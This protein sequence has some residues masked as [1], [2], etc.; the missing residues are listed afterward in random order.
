MTQLKSGIIDWTTALEFI[1]KRYQQDHISDRYAAYLFLRSEEE[2][3]MPEE[4]AK[5]ILS[6]PENYPAYLISFAEQR[7]RNYVATNI[8][9]VGEIALRD[10]WFPLQ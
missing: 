5:V 4:I 9:P 8:L 7:F 6:D 3:Q 2:I 10:N 1:K